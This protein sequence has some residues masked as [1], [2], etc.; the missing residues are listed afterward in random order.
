M[1]TVI[2]K[3]TPI[4]KIRKLIKELRPKQTKDGL[5][6]LSGK[7]VLTRDPVGWQKKVRDEWK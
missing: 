6:A 1:V 4:P 2:R 5:I 3:N 7:L